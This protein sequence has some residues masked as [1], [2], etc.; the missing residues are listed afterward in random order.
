MIIVYL[1]A[2]EFLTNSIFSS[3]FT[4]S[5]TAHLQA[6]VLANIRKS[7]STMTAI[8]MMTIMIIMIMMIIIIIT[9]LMMLMIPVKMEADKKLGEKEVTVSGEEVAA[10]TSMM[11]C[12]YNY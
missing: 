8:I 12:D 7:K 4:G 1:C 3:F 6:E 2:F 9:S 11:D 10:A 5:G